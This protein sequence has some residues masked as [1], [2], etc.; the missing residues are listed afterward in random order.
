MPPSVY[1]TGVTIYHPD[2]CWGGYTLIPASARSTAK[3]A[4][5][6]D[7]N[8]RSIKR[9][10]GV[11]GCFD[12]KLLPGG[13]ILG[14]S[15]ATKGHRFD[16]QDLIQV[17]WDHHRVWTFNRAEQLEIDGH[18]VWSA[19]AHHDFQRQGNPVGY[20]AP[21]QP[22][23][24]RGTTLLNSTKMVS[25]PDIAPVPLADTRVIDVDPDGNVIWEWLLTDHW[26]ELGLRPGARNAYY[27]N[28]GYMPQIGYAKEVYLN[29]IA[30]L[31]PNKWYE[32]GDSRFH[33]DNIITDSRALNCSFI[34]SRETGAIV[35][36]LG[37]DYDTSPALEAI[38]VIIG[39]HQVHMIPEGLPGAGNIL[40]FD[41]GGEAGYGDP[42]PNTLDSPFAGRRG[43]SRVLELDPTSLDIVWD[44]GN[45]QYEDFARRTSRFFSQICSGMQRLPNGNTLICE[46]TSARVFEVT[47][48]REIV[49]E[50]VDPSG[51]VFRAH[52]YP[53]DWV[54][55]VAPP[56]D[57]PV[58]LP[59]N[60]Q[61][62]PE[63]L[64]VREADDFYHHSPE[65]PQFPTA[66]V[67]S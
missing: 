54:P 16:M 65:F 45:Y 48:E 62:S 53:Y 11:F 44:Y 13:A 19:R 61:L 20:F 46:T 39:Q 36:K 47:P 60:A 5:L 9:W 41:N 34:I 32:A 33:P 15:G 3:G 56:V 18:R 28:P 1:P 23:H 31:G 22:P 6:I 42:N 50:Y 8:G 63:G 27:L 17:D 29:N 64:S 43:Y 52:R 21:E 35:W 30:W 57:R 14:S 26:D 67:R 37:P 24:P 10:E 59:P 55:E 49:W 66:P 12:N 51:F 7:M 38:G 2:K 40:L 4:N 58:H 25:R